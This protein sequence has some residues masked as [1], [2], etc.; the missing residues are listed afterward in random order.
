[1][2]SD[3]Q[4]NGSTGDMLFISGYTSKVAGT[5]AGVTEPQTTFSACFGVAFLPLHPTK[6]AEMLSK[7]LKESECKCLVDKAQV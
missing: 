1:M 5:E 2:P 3:F 6:Y 7:K 4:I